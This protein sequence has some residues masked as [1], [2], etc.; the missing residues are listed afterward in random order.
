LSGLNL[1]LFHKDRTPSTSP[2]LHWAWIPAFL[3]IFRRTTFASP[4]ADMSVPVKPA[5]NANQP[6]YP[7][8]DEPRQ[9]DN[10]DMAFIV[11][12]TNGGQ[13]AALREHVLRVWQR[14][15]QEVCKSVS[16]P[17]M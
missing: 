11:E 17:S 1:H 2:V 12:Y 15:K 4:T 3:E 16:R 9:L 13:V 7:V 14:A 6:H 8:T 10:E 5:G